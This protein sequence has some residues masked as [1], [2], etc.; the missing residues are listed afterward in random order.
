MKIRFLGT[1]TSQGIPV[2]GCNCEVCKS[3]DFRD[4][5]FRTSAHIEINGKSIV[6]DTGPDFRM[7]M[8]R[9]GISHLDAVLFTHEHKDHTA[10]LDDIRPFNFRQ[11]RDMPI[12]GRQQVIDQIKREFS[13]IFSEVKYPGVPRV[14]TNVID[15]APF[16]VEGI[17]VTPIPVMHHKLPVLGFRIGDFTYITDANFI[18]EE[19]KKL[20]QGSKILVLNALQ[21]TAHQSHFTL[22]EA[23]EQVG[24]L[25]V[26]QAYFTHISHKLGLHQEVEKELPEGIHL[27]YD[28]LVLNLP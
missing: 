11:N 1:G 28:G 23:I 8:L 15:H 10:G 5:R 4:Q 19:S 14:I 21:K 20:I 26:E 22:E 9:A 16:E 2:I 18:S 17:R 27:A 6:I 12:Y 24:S 7:Q 25:N 3:L 13:Y